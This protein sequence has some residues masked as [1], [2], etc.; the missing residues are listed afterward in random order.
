MKL[1]DLKFER[2]TKPRSELITASD[3]AAILNLSPWQSPRDVWMRKKHSEQQPETAAMRR[4]TAAEDVLDDWYVMNGYDTVPPMAH[5]PGLRHGDAPIVGPEDWMACSPDAICMDGNDDLYLVEY[6]TSSQPWFKGVPNYY[7]EQVQWQLRCIPRA[8][9]AVLVAVTD[10]PKLL[11]EMLGNENVIIRH[12]GQQL[13][14]SLLSHKMLNVQ[15]WVIERDHNTESHKY[16]KAWYDRHMVLGVEPEVSGK[17]LERIQSTWAESGA[18]KSV[19]ADNLKDPD[20]I[21]SLVMQLGIAE[22]SLEH[23]ENLVR[24]IKSELLWEWSQQSKDADSIL[25]RSG[26]SISYKLQKGRTMIDTE[27]LRRDYPTIAAEYTKEGAAFRV[28]RT[29]K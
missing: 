10:M 29:P 27:R 1:Q 7:V 5:M 26:K 17:D 13:M 25:L 16:I 21:E 15:C 12:E 14:R 9:Y 23:A 22:Q 28:L 8:K 2:S 11:D 3:V 18:D 20:K 19:R 4:G 24:S 6:K